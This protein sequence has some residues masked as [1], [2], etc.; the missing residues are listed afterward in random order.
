MTHTTERQVSP[1]QQPLRNAAVR[2]NL[3]TIAII[4]V[5]FSGGPF[6]LTWLATSSATAFLVLMF[7]R[8]K[9]QQSLQ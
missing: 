7:W 2:R 8:I 3:G 9:Q 6:G 1:V 4:A 5:A